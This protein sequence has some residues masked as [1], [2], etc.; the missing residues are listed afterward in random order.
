MAYTDQAA[1]ANDVTFRDRVRVAIVTAAIAVMGE[2]QTGTDQQYGKRQALAYAMLTNSGG[3]LERFAWGVVAN[4]AITGASNDG[5][6]QFTVD[7]LIDDMAGVTQQ[8]D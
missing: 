8:D 6:I 3:Y 7:S 2:T 1:L 4:A 5:D